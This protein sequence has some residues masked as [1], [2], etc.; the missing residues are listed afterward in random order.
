MRMIVQCCFYAITFEPQT[1]ERQSRA[2]MTRI[3]A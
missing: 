3:L 1:L 2:I